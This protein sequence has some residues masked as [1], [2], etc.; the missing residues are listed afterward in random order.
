MARRRRVVVIGAGVL[1]LACAAELSDAAD[2][3]ITVLDRRAP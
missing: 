1:G 3:D 2:L